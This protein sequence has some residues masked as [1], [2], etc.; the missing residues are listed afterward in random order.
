MEGDFRAFDSS[1]VGPDLFEGGVG[2]DVSAPFDPFFLP[3]VGLDVTVVS[4][5]VSEV[6]FVFGGWTFSVHF[7]GS[8]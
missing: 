8:V 7:P 1:D 5:E 2:V 6:V 4:D 3:D